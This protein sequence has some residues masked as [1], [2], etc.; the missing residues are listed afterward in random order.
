MYEPLLIVLS[1]L[2]DRIR[3]D[4]FHFYGRVVDKLLYGWVIAALFQHPFDLF[5]PAIMLAFVLGSS[6]GWGDTMGAIME[7]RD[8]KPET[9]ARDHFWQVGVLRTNKWAAAVV[10]G[11]LW[12]LP[13][14]LLGWFDPVLYWAV[15]IYTVAYLVSLVLASYIK[16]DSW[17][18]AEVIRGLIAGSLVWVVVLLT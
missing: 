13:I 16:K 4:A 3:G 1:G 8:L 11:A 17:S 14:A 10:R 2:L 18:Q 15:P 12:G 6:P 9:V 5:T 7:D